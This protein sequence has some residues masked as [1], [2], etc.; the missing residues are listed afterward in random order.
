MKT[1][2]HQYNHFTSNQAQTSFAKFLMKETLSQFCCTDDISR[3]EDYHCHITEFFSDFLHDWI[4]AYPLLHYYG[5]ALHNT[6][7]YQSML[8]QNE[9]HRQAIYAR[10]QRYLCFTHRTMFL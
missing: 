4:D 3:T 7:D 2:H 5:F 10:Q 9:I 6:V 1:T 8:H